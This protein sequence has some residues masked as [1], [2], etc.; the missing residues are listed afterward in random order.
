MNKLISNFNPS[1]I[2]FQKNKGKEFEGHFG[3]SHYTFRLDDWVFTPDFAEE[4]LNKHFGTKSLK[5]F[6][7]DTLNEAVIAAGAVFHYLDRGIKHS[8]KI[9]KFN[10]VT[11]ELKYRG[12]KYNNVA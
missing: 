9:E 1:E 11:K 3:T 7:V 8:N 10:I 4:I 5:G 6:G 12:I 2:L